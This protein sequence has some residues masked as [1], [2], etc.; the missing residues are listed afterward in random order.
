MII[1]N[2]L[3]IEGLKLVNLVEYHRH[4]CLKNDLRKRSQVS[5]FL[6]W[7]SEETNEKIGMISRE[8]KILKTDHNLRKTPE[9]TFRS[10]S[11]GENWSLV[12]PT[13]YANLSHCLIN[14]KLSH[15]HVDFR[16]WFFNFNRL[17]QQNI[18]EITQKPPWCNPMSSAYKVYTSHTSVFCNRIAKSLDPWRKFPDCSTLLLTPTQDT[19]MHGYKS[20]VKEEE[21]HEFLNGPSDEKAL[22]SHSLPHCMIITVLKDNAVST[23]WYRKSPSVSPDCWHCTSILAL[24]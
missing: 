15:W 9:Q 4:P 22:N 23:N 16:K 20:Q 13:K 17:T 18:T 12:L 21:K 5:Y 1:P 3:N 8:F 2:P 14:Q 24:F 10:I 6:E 7:I 19:P 11:S